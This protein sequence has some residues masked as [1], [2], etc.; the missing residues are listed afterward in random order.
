MDVKEF[1]RLISFHK[2]MTLVDTLN[3]LRAGESTEVVEA[4]DARVQE[5]KLQMAR[6]FSAARRIANESKA[7]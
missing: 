3:A 6:E 1:R 2:D 4:I 7:A 5:F